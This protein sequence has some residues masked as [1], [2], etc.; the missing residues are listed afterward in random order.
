[1]KFRIV[2]IFH[3]VG[4]LSQKD[5][6]RS[7]IEYVIQKKNFWGRWKEVFATEIT[8]CR[9]AHKTYADAEAY[10]LHYYMGHGECEKIGVEYEYTPY[11]YYTG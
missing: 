8:P 11:T 5:G 10:M 3:G 9:V 7:K 2:Q 4:E 6:G 1:M